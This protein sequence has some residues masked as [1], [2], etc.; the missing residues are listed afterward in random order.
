MEMDRRSSDE[1][2]VWLPAVIGR[3]LALG[4]L[5]SLAMSALMVLA[6]LG[7]GL[8]GGDTDDWRRDESVPYLIVFGLF[9]FVFTVIPSSLAGS[10]NAVVLHRLWRRARLST[11]TGLLV[12]LVWGFLAGLVTYQVIH[13]TLRAGGPPIGYLA[14]VFAG[15]ASAV[16]SWHGWSMTRYLRHRSRGSG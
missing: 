5:G 7:I 4:A 1:Y 10:L 13:F 8:A 11:L 14:F 2:R 16:G 6:L 3:G 12:G 15:I 9:G